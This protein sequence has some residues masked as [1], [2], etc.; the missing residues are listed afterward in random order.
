MRYVLLA[1]AMISGATIP[2]QIAANKRLFEAVKSPVLT[3]AI[4]LSLSAILAWIIS[5]TVPAARGELSGAT[6]TPWWAWLSVVL[7]TFAIVVQISNAKQEGSGPLIALIVAGQLG[8]AM[9]I[10]HFGALGM[11]KEPIRWW[12]VVGAA[13]MVGGAAV[14]QIKGK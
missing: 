12:K 6:E 7:I 11:E 3:V 8:C 14:M 10:D 1:L 2:I 9:L 5:F 13:A 4:V